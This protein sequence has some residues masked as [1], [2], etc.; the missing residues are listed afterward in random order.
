[1]NDLGSRLTMEKIYITFPRAFWLGDGS[2]EDDAKFTGFIQWLSP[3]YSKETNPACWNQEAAD[4]ST[5]QSSCAHPTL[6]FYIYG[7]Q[8]ETLATTLAALPS[9]A[10][11]DEYISTFFK[12]YFSR[13]PYYIEGSKDC[14]PVSCYATTW[15][16]D[17]LAGN[18]SYCTFR[19]GLQEGDL[20]S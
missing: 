3:L 2:N 15:V 17:D 13:L 4:L 5:L 20:L 19:T 1:M 10:K 16:L 6:L 8:S 9:Q 7:D 14:I 11:R 18:G 12:P